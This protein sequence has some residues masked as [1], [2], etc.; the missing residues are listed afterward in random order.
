MPS[1]GKM[2]EEVMLDLN[3]NLGRSHL[4][5]AQMVDRACQK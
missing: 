2:A 4:L 1:Q 3:L 5:G